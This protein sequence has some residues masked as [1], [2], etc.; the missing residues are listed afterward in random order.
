MSIMASV[1]TS[2][3]NADNTEISGDLVVVFCSSRHT[4]HVGK[5]TFVPL[6]TESMRNEKGTSDV[7]RRRSRRTTVP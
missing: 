5:L 6:A 4:M 1:Y 7:P 2:Y 3:A